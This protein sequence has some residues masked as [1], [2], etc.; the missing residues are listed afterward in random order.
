MMP[1]V[2]ILSLRNNLLLALRK[3]NDDNRLGDCFGDIIHLFSTFFLFEIICW[4]S[5]L[6]RSRCRHNWQ[7]WQ[8]NTSTWSRI[9]NWPVRIDDLTA[10]ESGLVGRK[11]WP[12]SCIE[13]YIPYAD[14][15]NYTSVRI[16]SSDNSRR[17]LFAGDKIDDRIGSVIRRQSGYLCALLYFY[18]FDC[19]FPN[20]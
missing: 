14:R 12:T 4:L 19:R 17:G 13:D 15:T 20:D 5:F 1:I 3:K 7:G 10:D 2:V 6:I 8:H 16:S 9:A 11:A 18:E